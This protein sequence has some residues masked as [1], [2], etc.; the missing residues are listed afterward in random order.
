M[1]LVGGGYFLYHGLPVL[2]HVAENWAS[3]VGHRPT[4]SYDKCH[5][6]LALSSIASGLIWSGVAVLIAS[7]FVRKNHKAKE[8]EH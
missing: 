7:F 6:I 2:H 1:F 3:L 5:S 8:I 4:S